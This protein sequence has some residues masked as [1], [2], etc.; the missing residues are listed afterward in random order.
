MPCHAMAA[1]AL[2]LVDLHTASP[3]GPYPMHIGL[4]LP[5]WLRT[6][7][8]THDAVL[9]SGTGESLQGS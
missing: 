3:E 7:A 1:S 6:R 5:Q 2:H 8:Y 9:D 4:H